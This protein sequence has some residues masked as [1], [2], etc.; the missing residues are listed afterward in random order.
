MLHR[1]AKTGGCQQCAEF[2]TVPAYCVGLVVQ[3][4][5]PHVRGGRMLQQVFLDGVPVAPGHRAQAAGDGGPGP[6][7][8]FEVRGEELDVGPAVGEQVEL[9]LVAPA[10]ELPQVQ[11]VGLPGEAAVS[12]QE[13]G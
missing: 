13:S 6:P 2:V 10:G 11:L 4:W 12:G 7:A 3:P 9:V 1:R 5:P 8:R